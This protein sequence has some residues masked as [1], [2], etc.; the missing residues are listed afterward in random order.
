MDASV[1]IATHNRAGYLRD[2]LRSLAALSSSARWEVIV[3]DNNS[4]DDTRHVVAAAAQDFP[5]ELRYCFEAEPGKPAALNAAQRLARGDVYVFTDDD[6]RFEVNWL[7]AAL[8]ALRQSGGDYVGGKVLP[9]WGGEP[10]LWLH[11]RPGSHWAVLA[12]LDFG[13]QQLEFG[14]GIGWP[15]GVNMAVRR[16]AILRV[17][18]WN[19]RFGRQGNTLRGQEQRE[20]CLRARAVG[21]RGFYAPQMIVHHIVPAERLT[22]RYFRRWLYWNGLSRAVLYQ[23]MKLDMESPD[24]STL[25]FSTVPHIAGMPRYMYRSAL[26]SLVRMGTA[27]SRR[28]PAAAFEHELK[29][30]FFAGALNQRWRTVSH[31]RAAL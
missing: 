20:W 29:L 31:R 30:W 2:T 21:L 4:R 12:L 15:L 14:K 7:E 3:V 1:L 19:N 6:A 25:D 10:P 13:S 24:D 23:N 17:G 18:P 5:V 27:I 26:R 16:D 9:I 22:K 8:D 28:D 11:N